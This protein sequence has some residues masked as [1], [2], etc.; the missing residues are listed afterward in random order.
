[1]K[2]MILSILVCSTC[3][4]AG[5]CLSLKWYNIDSL[6]EANSFKRECINV[7]DEALLRVDTI[8]MN[9]DIYD[10]DGSDTMSDYLDLREKLDSLYMTQL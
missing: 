4:Y 1:M 8:M 10:I 7:A 2:K 9:N 6:Y 5:W 3:F